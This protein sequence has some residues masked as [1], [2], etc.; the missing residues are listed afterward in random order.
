M[1][2]TTSD[3]TVNGEIFSVSTSATIKGA[4]TINFAAS[5]ET[6]I[7]GTL[8]VTGGSLILAGGSNQIK[9]VNF[10]GNDLTVNGWTTVATTLTAKS[11]L[12]SFDNNSILDVL[13]NLTVTGIADM[14]LDGTSTFIGGNFMVTTGAGVNTI[15]VNKLSVNGTTNVNTSTGDGAGAAGADQI[16]VNDSDFGGNV[17]LKTGAGD[18]VLNVETLDSG[19]IT[20][21]HGTVAIDLGD[22]DDIGAI[23]RPFDANDFISTDDKVTLAGGSGFDALQMLTSNNLFFLFPTISPDLELLS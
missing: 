14:T 12:G 5:V 10:N 15:A 8:A 22:G 6:T 13:G 7:R 20:A 3:L 4:S 21:F 23:G 11:A 16:A 1:N 17:T 19:Q 18:D 2:L 9:S